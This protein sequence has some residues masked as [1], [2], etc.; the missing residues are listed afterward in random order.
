MCMS[1][2][3]YSLESTVEISLKVYNFNYNNIGLA[4]HQ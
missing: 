3:T 2:S 4:T 1:Q